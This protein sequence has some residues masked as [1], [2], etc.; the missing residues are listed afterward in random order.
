MH[1]RY[2][3]EV[4][5]FRELIDWHRYY[6]RTYDRDKF[7]EMYGNDEDVTDLG[8]MSAKEM[9][10]MLEAIE[11]QRAEARQREQKPMTDELV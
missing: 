5:T 3:L 4:I 11:A 9:H 7:L 8:D 2:L 10:D 1:P 6:L